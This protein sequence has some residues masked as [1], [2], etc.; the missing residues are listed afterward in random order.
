L[1]FRR[2]AHSET[3]SVLCDFQHFDT[4]TMT[5][6]NRISFAGFRN[7]CTHGMA[8][9]LVLARS[10][11]RTTVKGKLTTGGQSSIGVK[12]IKTRASLSAIL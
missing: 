2:L 10:S 11:K 8:F 6:A 12:F 4:E 7:D 9:D 3:L 1:N 5:W